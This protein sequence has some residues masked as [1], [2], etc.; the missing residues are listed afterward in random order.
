MNKIIIILTFSLLSLNLSFSQNTLNFVKEDITFEIKDSVFSVNGIYYLHASSHGKFSI[1]YPFPTDSIYG[2]PNEIS[3]HDINSG[4]SIA[5]KKTS[6]LSSIVF[7]TQANIK[8]PLKISYQQSLKSNRARYILLTTHYWKKALKEVDYKLVTDINFKI[9][10]FSIEPD[11]AFE[12]N[13]KMVYIWQK[14]DY[15]PN[16]DF[17]IDF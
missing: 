13:G 9:K 7:Q 12:L 10:S 2:E 17:I 5:F 6:D 15:L 11:T 16:V 14:K 1:L 8:S 4:R 3:V